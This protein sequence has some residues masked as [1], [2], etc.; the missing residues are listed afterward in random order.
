MF[1]NVFLYH[2]EKGKRD[3]QATGLPQESTNHSAAWKQPQHPLVRLEPRRCFTRH[4][5]PFLSAPKWWTVAQTLVI[6]S[7]NTLL[8]CI[9]SFHCCKC[10]E[11]S[12]R[13]SPQISGGASTPAAAASD[14]CE[15]VEGCCWVSVNNNRDEWNLFK[16]NYAII[17]S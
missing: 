13:R 11:G 12:Q 14:R 3:V 7:A 5:R 6:V 1:V 4:L 9:E 2:F 8:C 17:F 10:G 16:C 15:S